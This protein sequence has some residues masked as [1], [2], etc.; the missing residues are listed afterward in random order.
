VVVPV[1]LYCVRLPA[2]PGHPG[3]K[4]CKT[5]VSLFCLFARCTDTL[6]YLHVLPVVCVGVD[7]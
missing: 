3:S 1:G 4:G 6:T 2:H 7:S 5:A